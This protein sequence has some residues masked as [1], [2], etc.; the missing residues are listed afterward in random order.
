MKNFDGLSARVDQALAA[1][2]QARNALK[3]L[4][5]A[6]KERVCFVWMDLI[7]RVIIY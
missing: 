2:K 7:D 3:D 6:T 5:E 4:I 1:E